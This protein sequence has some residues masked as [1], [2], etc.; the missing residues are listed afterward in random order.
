MTGRKG[1]RKEG[2]EEGVGVVWIPAITN[3]PQPESRRGEGRK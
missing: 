1:V 2:S 3:V